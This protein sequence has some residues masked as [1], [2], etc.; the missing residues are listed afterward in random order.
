MHDVVQ[1]IDFVREG[2]DGLTKL[3]DLCLFGLGTEETGNG[4]TASA[5]LLFINCFTLQAA[6]KFLL[7]LPDFILLF[8]GL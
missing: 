6:F 1:L 4:R 3:V 5:Q 7:V 8:K 2:F